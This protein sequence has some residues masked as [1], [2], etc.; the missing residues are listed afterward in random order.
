MNTVRDRLWIWGHEGA[1][2]NTEWNLPAPSRITPAEAAHYLGIPN[3]LMVTYGGKPEPPFDQHA[4]ALS[5]LDRV[6]WSIVGDSSSKRNDES[7]DLDEVIGLAEKFPNI[8]GAIMDDFFNSV[9]DED[10]GRY[11]TEELRGFQEKLHAAKRALDLWVVLYTH[12]LDIAFEKHVDLCDVIT[13]WTWKSPDLADLERNFATL[14]ERAPD[15]RIILGCYLWD[16]G[17]KAPMPLDRMKMQNELALKWLKAGDIEGIIMLSN[18]V[19]DIGLDAVEWTKDWIAEVGG[20][21][22]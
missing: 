19:C 8:T 7:T 13:F 11:G 10:I 21:T 20:E 14:K 16:Y 9:T 12:Q 5:S 6:V 4:L 2:H 1:S 17:M 3:A 15:K 22:L 18:C